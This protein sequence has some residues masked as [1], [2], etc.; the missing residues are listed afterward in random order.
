MR[1]TSIRE[2]PA[3]WDNGRLHQC[4]VYDDTGEEFCC[5]CHFGPENNAIMDLLDVTWGYAVVED[6]M[7]ILQHA[8]L[9]VPYLHVLVRK[10]EAF[11]TKDQE[12]IRRVLE[13][14]AD[15][16]ARLDKIRRLPGSH[17]ERVAEDPKRRG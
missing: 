5:Y 13:D 15:E 16:R 14:I 10:I 2:L 9:P 4:R 3:E 7:M 12:Q 8:V 11:S 6:R 1:T 17:K